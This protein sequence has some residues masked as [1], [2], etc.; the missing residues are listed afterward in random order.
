MPII[1]KT[2]IIESGAEIGEGVTIGAYAFVGKHVVIGEGTTIA[3]GAHIEG[4]TTIG[5]NNKIFPYAVLGTAPQDLK[6]N[7][8]PTQLVIGEGNTFREFTQVNI[9]TEHGGGVTRIANNSLFM[10]HVHIAHDN[11]IGERVV[12]ANFVALAGHVELGDFVV[13]GGESAIHQFV[14]IGRNTMI[15]GASA[16]SQDI[17]PFC[18]AEGNRAVIRGLNLV[19]LR[20]TLS[21]EAIDALKPIF[22]DVF[23]SNHSPKAVAE[24]LIT[25]ALSAEA[26]EFCEFIINAKRGVPSAHIQEQQ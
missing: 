15:A 20:R 11:I 18:L 10:G 16:V 17:P 26:K 2:A 25:Q 9:G 22:K 4:H 6:Y 8:E 19:G 14:R 5:K 3:H 13:V 7:G 24:Q 23:R 1:D 12:I 21:R